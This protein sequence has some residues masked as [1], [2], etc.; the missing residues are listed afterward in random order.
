MLHCRFHSCQFYFV[1]VQCPA[2]QVFEE[3]GDECYRTCEDLQYSE[4][5]KSSCVEGCRCPTGQS[6]DENNECIPTGKCQCAH[7]GLTFKSGYKEV[8]PGVKFLE[9]W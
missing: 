5:C 4:P 3:C 7:N 2:G 6:L 1:A 9:L 8:R